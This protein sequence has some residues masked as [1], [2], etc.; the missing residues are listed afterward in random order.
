MPG[1]RQRPWEPVHR[2]APPRPEASAV[3]QAAARIAPTA[4]LS[5][6][7]LGD[8]RLA[9]RGSGPVRT[10]LVQRMQTT[11]GNRA[12]RRLIQR[13]TATARRPLQREPDAPA[14]AAEAAAPDEEVAADL[15]EYADLQVLAAA[16]AEEGGAAEAEG[17]GE[18]GAAPAPVQPWRAGNLAV[19][20]GKPKSRRMVALGATPGKGSATGRKV[21]VRWHVKNKARWTGTPGKENY[22]K[23]GKWEV[24]VK[25]KLGVRTWM[26][27]DATIHMG[28]RVAAVDFWE[29]GASGGITK[30]K[31]TARYKNFTTAAH[32]QGFKSKYARQFMLYD[33]NYRFEY[34][35]A[36]SSAGASMGTNYLTLPPGQ[37]QW[38]T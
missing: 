10:A 3:D 21:L 26:K 18:T 22:K 34:G 1:A 29:K 19:Q 37:T 8:S 36:N 33:Q 16:V 23:P 2:Q 17:E 38:P 7:L 4:T 12:V 28:H 25:D 11:V 24:H 5:P 32:S 35:P 15:E 31:H 9:G 13:G 6:T 20:R 30:P 27:L 14:P